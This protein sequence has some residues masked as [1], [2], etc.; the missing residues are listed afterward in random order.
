[1][2]TVWLKDFINQPIDNVLTGVPPEKWDDGIFTAEQ[3]KRGFFHGG[4]ALMFGDILYNYDSP[5]KIWQAMETPALS[6]VLQPLP[7]VIQASEE[8]VEN[9]DL[10]ESSE[11]RLKELGM[12]FIPGQNWWAIQPFLEG[13]K[14]GQIN[15]LE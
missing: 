13:F 7:L 11:K 12:S 3:V 6:A 8:L 5:N 2:M 9:Q 10:S 4:A 14:D 15:I 1:M